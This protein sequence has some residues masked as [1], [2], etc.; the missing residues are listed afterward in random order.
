MDL[1]IKWRGT[2]TEKEKAIVLERSF[3]LGWN[4]IVW[5]TVLTGKQLQNKP[6]KPPIAST[7]RISD[8]QALTQR[9]LVSS[10]KSKFLALADT[11]KQM[12]RITVNVDEVIDAQAL[13][14]GNDYLRQYDIV[15]ACPSNAK[16]FAYLCKSADIDL[17][18]IDFTRRLAFPINKKLVRLPFLK[19]YFHQFSFTFA[20][21]LFIRLTKQLAEESSLKYPT[22]HC[23][24]EAP[25]GGKSSP[26]RRFSFSSYAVDI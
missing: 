13:T 14:V 25:E 21:F 3:I 19:I 16:V 17:I 24:R 18:S 6:T 4:V 22:Q 10:S 5:N 9:R 7:F 2:F 1:N 11:L 12:N 15:A 20:P 23:C 8:L 26:A